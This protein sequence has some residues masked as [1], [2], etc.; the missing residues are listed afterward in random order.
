M[1]SF[2]D[3]SV[4]TDEVRTS[5]IQHKCMHLIILFGYLPVSGLTIL[6]KV[7]C[8]FFFNVGLK[9]ERCGRGLGGSSM[10]CA[11]PTHLRR[12]AGALSKSP[13]NGAGT[14]CAGIET[15]YRGP[16]LS[17]DTTVPAPWEEGV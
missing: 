11:A 10:D 7:K 8:F 3:T 13:G 9:R 15:R 12:G 2:F 1:P 14:D 16:E 5:F 4:K 6:M 17:T